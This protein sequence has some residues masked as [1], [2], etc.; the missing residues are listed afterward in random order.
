MPSRDIQSILVV[1]AAGIGNT[2]LAVPM[3]TALKQ[4]LPNARV[5]V[6]V[7]VEAAAKLLESNPNIAESVVIPVNGSF[8]EK[9]SAVLRLRRRHFDL[10]ITAAPSARPVYQLFAWLVGARLRIIHDYEHHSFRSLTWLSPV[11]VPAPPGR[12]D[13]KQNMHLLQPLGISLKKTPPVRIWLNESELQKAENW[14]GKNGLS[15]GNFVALNPSTDSDVPRKKRWSNKALRSM[16]EAGQRIAANFGWKIL[17]I[18]DH[19][20]RA[21]AE[22]IAEQL[23]GETPIAEGLPIRHLAAIISHAGCLIDLDSGIGHIGAAVGVPVVSI[24]GMADPSRT[25]PW[26]SSTTVVRPDCSCAPCYSY[27]Y[28]SLH[29]HVECTALDCLRD[30]S[31][32]DTVS[33]ALQLLSTRGTG[34]HSGLVTQQADAECME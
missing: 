21:F 11:K 19:G 30:I 6:A 31:V 7:R 34:R 2:L 9:I 15:P 29:P 22:F 12:H 33:Q 27:P 16:A 3:I 23:P 20:E 8:S 28:E 32:S 1:S 17:L 5:T 18:A 25:R 24:F 10:C 4:R 26:G 13:V 14:L